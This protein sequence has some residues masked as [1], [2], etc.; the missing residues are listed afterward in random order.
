MHPHTDQI[1]RIVHRAR[2]SL[3]CLTLTSC[4]YLPLHGNTEYREEET[5]L[6]YEMV[7]P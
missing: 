3:T 7:Q 6:A 5:T 2:T 4:D 1:V